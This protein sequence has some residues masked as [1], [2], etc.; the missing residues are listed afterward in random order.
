MT[1]ITLIKGQLW[2]ESPAILS[3]EE[4]DLEASPLLGIMSIINQTIPK[5]L[6]VTARLLANY[7]EKCGV[8]R[9]SFVFIYR[10]LLI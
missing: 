7:A 8:I 9:K 4:E 3:V 5:F 1:F 10:L 6:L 2:K